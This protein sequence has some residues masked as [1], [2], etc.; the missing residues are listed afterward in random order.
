[1]ILDNSNNVIALVDTNL[2]SATYGTDILTEKF[3]SNSGGYRRSVHATSLLT[4]NY[5]GA[6][7]N[8]SFNCYGRQTLYQEAK[9]TNSVV[10]ATLAGLGF[11]DGTFNGQTVIVSGGLTG[12]R[13]KQDH[14]EFLPGGIS[15]FPGGG[16]G[17]GAFPGVPTP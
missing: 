12:K 6:T 3:T 17:L 7:L 1:M 9:G 16:G 10:T 4:L 5:T 15:T 2:L 8:F 11:G 13:T 14:L